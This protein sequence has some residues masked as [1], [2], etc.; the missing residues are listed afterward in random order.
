LSFIVSYYVSVCY[1]A[2][3][4]PILLWFL[5]NEALQVAN[6]AHTKNPTRSGNTS[7]RGTKASKRVIAPQEQDVPNK[8]TRQKTRDLALV[9][10]PDPQQVIN[11]G[12]PNATPTH[13]MLISS[14]DPSLQQDLVDTVDEGK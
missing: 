8:V 7:V 6:V 5:P 12:L 2:N 10:S 13:D 3:W 14:S 11:L 1:L 4:V 9:S